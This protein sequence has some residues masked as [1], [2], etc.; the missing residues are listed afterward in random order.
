M[1]HLRLGAK[2]GEINVLWH[3]A[4]MFR[5]N[6]GRLRAT[7]ITLGCSLLVCESSFSS[8]SPLAHCWKQADTRIELAPCLKKLLH[9]AEDRLKSTR[10]QVERGAAE[11]DRVTDYRWNNLEQTRASDV[12]WRA[13]RDVE[14]DRQAQAMSPGTGSGDVYLAC[15][16]MLTKE[17]IQHLGG[18]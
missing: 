4:G 2:G 9:D 17:R 10:S 16:I 3:K 14:C 12:R 5:K 7:V 11:L 1:H 13:Y 18:P 6:C 8:E 15:R